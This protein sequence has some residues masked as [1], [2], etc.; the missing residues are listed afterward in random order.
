MTEN[1]ETQEHATDQAVALNAMVR[2]V[3]ECITRNIGKEPNELWVD[4]K[5]SDALAII[6]ELKEYEELFNLQ[7]TRLDSASKYWQIMNGQSNTFP[8][9]GELLEFLMTRIDKLEKK[10][11]EF[12]KP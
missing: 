9:L 2:A 1:N 3:D 4:L 5:V 10:L 7:K 8:D 11:G 12:I 6:A